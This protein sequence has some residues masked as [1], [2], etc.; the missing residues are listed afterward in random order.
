MFSSSNNS[1]EA[2]AEGGYPSVYVVDTHATRPPLPPRLNQ[3]KRATGPAQT[4]LF[5]LVSL[6]LCGMVIEACFI[7][8]LYQE[9]SATQASFSK[10]IAESSSP[11]KLPG[12]DILPSKPV[13]HLTDGHDP[14]VH[15]KTI[16]AWNQNADP[17]LYQMDY[18]DGKLIILKEGFYYVYSKIYFSEHDSFHHFVNLSTERY[19]GEYITLLE[20]RYSRHK[21]KNSPS[22]SNMKSN[23]YLS[24]V[25]HL[26]KNDA[27]CVSVK[28]MS[29]LIRYKP[30]ENV[31]GAYM[32]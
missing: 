20:S 6:A 32:I 19:A 29:Q 30:S 10:L 23:S 24:G 26:H 15:G 14:K 8:R 21:N 11:T 22:L 16:M 12:Q 27:L 4:L 5:L 18:K 1:A 25:F 13:A 28:N 2:V 9:E 17:L 31:F 7:Y 3:R